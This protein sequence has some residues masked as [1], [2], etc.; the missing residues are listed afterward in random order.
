MKQINILNVPDFKRPDGSWGKFYSEASE[1]GRLQMHTRS[2]VLWNNV[3]NRCRKGSAQQRNKINYSE[4]SNEFL[5]YDHFT[6]WCQDQYGYLE[7]NPNGTFW[8]LDKDILFHNNK[9]YSPETCMFVPQVVNNLLVASDLCRGDL[10]VGVCLHVQGKCVK[11][12]AGC[13]KRDGSNYIGVFYTP[14]EAHRAWQKAKIARLWEE[15]ND[16]EDHE[17]LYG[18]LMLHI[19]RIQSDYDDGRETKVEWW[20]VRDLTIQ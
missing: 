8:S 11:F 16:V 1:E 3:N 17:K 9:V 6:D 14:E 19:N 5:N 4:A 2:C 20:T 10:P 15:A 13:R 12:M 18:A 7:K